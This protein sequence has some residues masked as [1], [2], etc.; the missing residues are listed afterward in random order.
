[1]SVLHET[2]FILTKHASVKM[3]KNKITEWGLDKNNKKEDVFAML[4]KKSERDA[5]GKKTAFKLRGRDVDFKDVQRYAARNHI[6]ATSIAELVTSHPQTPPD[7]QYLTPSPVLESTTGRDAN[8]VQERTL[9]RSKNVMVGSFE[10]KTWTPAPDSLGVMVPTLTSA[11][12]FKTQG[13]QYHFFISVLSQHIA[14]MATSLLPVDDPRCCLYLLLGRLEGHQLADLRPGLNQLMVDEAEN[15]LGEHNLF[16]IEKR[17]EVFQTHKDARIRHQ[18]LSQT[19]AK[20][21]KPFGPQDRGCILVLC[22]KA[23]SFFCVLDYVVAEKECRR[24]LQL[25]E[26]SIDQPRK[27]AR[28]ESGWLYSN[29]LRLL[30]VVQHA[31]GNYWG[32][33][34][35]LRLSISY[36]LS[37]VQDRGTLF[38]NLS[39]LED[40]LR[41]VRESAEADQ[42]RDRRMALVYEDTLR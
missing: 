29:T 16:S 10:N 15:F 39:H 25:L 38:R 28:G 20:L 30:A 40:F 7:L 27:N 18:L 1:V 36:T 35:S 17:D 14:N 31:Q 26:P 37:A 19:L 8:H 24:A 34:S 5:A 2:C 4:R 22:L 3:W 13:A 11:M 12:T 9:Q 21:E 23:E 42:I 33:I 6:S 41:D 32:A